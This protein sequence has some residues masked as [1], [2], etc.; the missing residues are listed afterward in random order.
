M[1]RNLRIIGGKWDPFTFLILHVL[2]MY[3]INHY[4]MAWLFPLFK[5][6]VSHH[7]NK[8]QIVSHLPVQQQTPL[9]ANFVITCCPENLCRK[10]RWKG[11]II[12]ELGER[13]DSSTHPNR[14]MTL[15]TV[16]RLLGVE[17][18]S[19]WRLVRFQG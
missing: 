18:L 19:N 2:G 5:L 9:Y 1:G 3:Y 16:W 7:P 4:K 8:Y 13:I 6:Y 11:L 17:W 10:R 15:L 14:L 12:D